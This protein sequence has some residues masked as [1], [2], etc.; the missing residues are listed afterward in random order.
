MSDPLYPYSR[1]AFPGGEDAPPRRYSDLEVDLIAARYTGTLPPHPSSSDVGAFDL[2]VGAFDSHIGAFDSYIGAFDSGVG[3][4]DSHVGAFDSSIGAFDSH[5]GAFDSGVGAFDSHIGVFDSHIAVRRS[6][7]ALYHQSFMGS[8]STVGQNEALYSSNTMAK[9][10]RRESSL[11]MYPQRPG[12]KDCDF[13]MRTRTCKYG[14]TCKFDHP[15]WV[16][17]GGV[18]NWKEIPDA[19]D[20]YPERP[21]EPDCP[22]FVKSN[23]CRFKDKCKFNHRKEKV[24]ALEPGTHNE[25]FLF[26]NSAILP[27]RPSKP[28]CSFYAKTGKCKFGTICKFN[29]P[30]DIEVPS[31]I[32]KETIYTATTGAKETIYTATTDAAAHIGAAD[33][34]V[35]AKTHAPT[36]PAEEHNPKGLPIRPGEVDC[37]FYMKTGSCKYGSTCRFNH[38]HRPVVDVA[39]MASLAQPILPTPAPAAALNPDANIVQ[40]FDFQA[41]HVPTEPVPII[42]PQRPGETVCDFYMKTGFCKYSQKCKFHHPINR[43][44]PGAYENGDAQQLATLTLAGL[45]RR[46][47]AEACAFYMRSGTCRYGTLCKFDHPP[48]QEAGAK[49]QADGKEKE[50]E[51]EKEGEEKEGLSVVLR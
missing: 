24:N 10:P 1:G 6:A 44:A 22:Y 14:E 25:Q 5:V 2:G 30:K 8:H 41:T 33:G 9:R 39:M 47:D 48:Q 19:E 36:A 42:Y 27:V 50:E 37:S 18:S 11:P 13:Y 38:P 12:K 15:Q 29:H 17:E 35:P 40:S 32:A 28:V 21:G 45:P 43:S 16:P 46:E 34:S 31:V 4:F 3:A 49:L 20:S 7:E 26:A 23:N 51:A